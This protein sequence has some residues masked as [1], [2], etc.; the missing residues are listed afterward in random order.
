VS[1]YLKTEAQ[2]AFEMSC[3]LK[4]LDDGQSPKKEVVSF[5]QNIL[6]YKILMIHNVR[7]C[8]C[9]R[10]RDSASCRGAKTSSRCVRA[11]RKFVNVLRKRS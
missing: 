9:L 2:Q 11:A 5:I 8:I 6:A 1:I 10:M 3:L 4:I 7:L